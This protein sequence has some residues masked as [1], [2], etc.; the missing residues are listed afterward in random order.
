M[1]EILQGCFEDERM[2]IARHGPIKHAVRNDEFR[3]QT[4]LKTVELA[5]GTSLEVGLK[6]MHQ[7]GRISTVEIGCFRG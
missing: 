6:F 2:V 3:T 4:I 1:F 5:D 7:E